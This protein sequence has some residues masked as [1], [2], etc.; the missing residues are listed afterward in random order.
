[1]EIGWR[2]D[3]QHWGLGYAPEAARACLDLA[4]ASTDDGGIG[5]DEVITFTA[6]TNTKSIRVMQKLGFERDAAGDFEHPGVPDGSPLRPHVLYRMTAER[7]GE[8]S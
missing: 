1:M 3:A 5:L 4:F 8:I 7:Y 2:I 6:I